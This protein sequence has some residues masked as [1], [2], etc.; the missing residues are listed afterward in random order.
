MEHISESTGVSDDINFLAA[1][2]DIRISILAQ[3]RQLPDILAIVFH[4]GFERLIVV[5]KGMIVVTVMVIVSVDVTM[6]KVVT[7]TVIV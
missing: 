4:V 6:S 7:V 1:L 5:G 3:F 2:Q